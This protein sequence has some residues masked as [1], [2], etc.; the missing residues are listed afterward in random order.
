MP[1]DNGTEI[2]GYIIERL[3]GTG[4]MGEVYLAQHPRLPR[5]DALKVLRSDV[6]ADSSFQER[7]NREADM[8]AQLWHPHIVGIHDRGTFDGRLWISMDFVDGTDTS[9]LLQERYPRGMPPREAIDIVKAVASALDYAHNQGLL[10]RDVKPANILVT[11]VHGERRILLGDFGVARDLSDGAEGGLTATNMVVGTMAYAAPEQLMGH[12]ID[13]RADQYAL[14][15][16]TYQ[17]LTGAA[18][19]ASSNVAVVIGRHLSEP[20]PPVSDVRPELAS[21]DAALAR[22]LAKEPD[23]RFASC[24]AFAR[25]L[26]RALDSPA[27]QPI[28]PG[29]APATR[30][31]TTPPPAFPSNPTPYASRSEVDAANAAPYV[32]SPPPYVSS[33]PPYV[34]NPAPHVSN[35]APHVSNPAPHVSNPHASAPHDS[36]PYVSAPY[37]AQAPAPQ[38]QSV[39]APVMVGLAAVS[40][41]IAVGVYFVVQPSS[42][43]VPAASSETSTQFIQ[44]AQATPPSVSTPPLDPEADS[45]AKLQQLANDDRPNVITDTWIPQLSSKRVGLFADGK[46]WTN[47]LILEQHMQ[48]RAQYPNVRLLWSGDWSTY[49]GRDF[50]ITVVGLPESNPDDVLT[51]CANQGYDRDNCIAK[52]VSNTLGVPCTTKLQP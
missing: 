30:L 46:V 27:P 2:A 1:L 4:G 43:D 14:A 38:R 50:W 41:I 42:T 12:A 20:P 31:R 19:F 11:D 48:M 36:N 16:T 34:S 5:K 25:T 15:A 32:S 29:N 17:L 9:H 23:D 40:V 44:T 8:V 47:A 7:F 28:P 10:H 39:L 51:W 33:P 6:S 35:P 3:L 49:D 22:G 26:E 13:G 18:L 37:V 21:L 45:L 52:I 24:M